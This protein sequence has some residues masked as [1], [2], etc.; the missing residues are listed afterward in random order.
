M[1]IENGKMERFMYSL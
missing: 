1:E